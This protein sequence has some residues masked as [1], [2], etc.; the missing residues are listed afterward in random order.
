V[1]TA[2][3]NW[4]RLLPQT[5]TRAFELHHGIDIRAVVVRLTTKPSIRIE[6][7]V[8]IGHYLDEEYVLGLVQAV[9]SAAVR[10]ILLVKREDRT[11]RSVE[12][13]QP[14]FQE[15]FTIRNGL[16]ARFSANEDP[17]LVERLQRELGEESGSS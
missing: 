11:W 16:K 8:F 17:E 13:L 12:S 14:D 4:R 1:R 6:G 5:R 10:K 9:L 2:P 15:F 3:S 7:D